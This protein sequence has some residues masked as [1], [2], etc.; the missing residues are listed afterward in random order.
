V[1]GAVPKL[2]TLRTEMTAMPGFD[3]RNLDQLQDRAL[4]AAYA[5]ATAYAPVTTPEVASLIEEGTPIREKLLATCELLVTF[6]ILDAKQVAEIRS[7][8]GNLDLAQDLIA[9]SALL[10]KHWAQIQ[11]KVPLTMDELERAR[12]VGSQLHVKLGERMPENAGTATT[13]AA[14]LR[15]ARAYTLL[16]NTYDACQ[17]AVYFLRWNE[18]DADRFAPSIFGKSGRRKEKAAPQSPEAPETA[19]ETGNAPAPAVAPAP[20]TPNVP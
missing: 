14:L 20:V 4:A 13:D 6:G 16:V 11:N 10:K 8:N 9:A 7:G 17:R 5:D 12:L 3:V 18:G 2:E 19:P 1:S 15:R